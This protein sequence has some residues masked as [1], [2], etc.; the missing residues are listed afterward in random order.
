MT[1]ESA[2]VFLV[3]TPGRRTSSSIRRIRVPV[4]GHPRH[5][6]PPAEDV[7][8]A[9]RRCVSRAQGREA[10]DHAQLYEEAIREKYALYS[11]GDSMLI[12]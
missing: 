9:P 12:R 6:L 1:K 7:A 2:I 3:P 4:G 5:E 10:A 11:F 8:H